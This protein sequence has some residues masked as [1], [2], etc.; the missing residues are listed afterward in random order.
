MTERSTRA[1]I[2]RNRYFHDRFDTQ[3]LRPLAGYAI[4]HIEQPAREIIEQADMLPATV[5]S[6]DCP[7]ARARRRDG[8][9]G[10]GR[11]GAHRVS[12]NRRP[13]VMPLYLC[14]APTRWCCSC[15]AS[16][17]KAVTVAGMVLFRCADGHVI[18]QRGVWD[19]LSLMQQLGVIAV[20]G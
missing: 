13:R 8:D 17:G 7:P 18:E 9:R 5:I 15:I 20:A 14:R 10:V 3:R 2:T 19:S 1:L 12:Q 6:V 4:D 16:T 11:P